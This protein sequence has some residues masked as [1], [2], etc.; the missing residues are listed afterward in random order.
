L[1]LTSSV[2]VP[3][4]KT[5]VP[6]SSVQ[7]RFCLLA[8]DQDHTT[9]HGSDAAER[10]PRRT[11]RVASASTSSVPEALIRRRRRQIAVPSL[12]NQ[13]RRIDAVDDMAPCLSTVT[14]S[15]VAV[16]SI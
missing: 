1:A 10:R 4:P 16:L 6:S 3:A 14:P 11:S 15:S 8:A 12:T 7:R 5:V 13:R 9:V 2:P